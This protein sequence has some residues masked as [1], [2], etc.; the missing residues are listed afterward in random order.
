MINII[1]VVVCALVV[2]I[3]F[4]IIIGITADEI[5]GKNRNK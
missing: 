2:V 4:G 1:I 3:S 5:S